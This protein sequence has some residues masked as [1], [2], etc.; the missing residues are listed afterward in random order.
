MS[1]ILVKIEMKKIRF[2]HQKKHTVLKK[3]F[4]NYLNNRGLFLIIDRTLINILKLILVI[5]S[6]IMTE[7]A[8]FQLILF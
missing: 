7:K 2:F 4:L 1:R 6:I 8:I 3:S 5:F